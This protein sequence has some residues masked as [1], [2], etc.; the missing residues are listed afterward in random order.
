MPL[1]LPPFGQPHDFGCLPTCVQAVRNFYGEAL[2]YDE[3][4]ELCDEIEPE[5]GCVWEQTVSALGY[6]YDVEELVSAGRTENFAALIQK[7]EQEQTPVICHLGWGYDKSQKHAVIVV[8]ASAEQ[9]EIM[10]PAPQPGGRIQVV[11]TAEFLVRWQQLQYGAFWFV[12]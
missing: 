2:T 11:T 9:V 8:S 10:N 4:S 6:H 3:A 7:V 5:G 12:E 1:D